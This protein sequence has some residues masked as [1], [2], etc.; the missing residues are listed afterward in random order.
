[1][2]LQRVEE[3]VEGDQLQSL[4]VRPNILEGHFSAATLDAQFCLRTRTIFNHLSVI[5]RNLRG[6]DNLRTVAEP[7]HTRQ[8][9]DG[10]GPVWSGNSK[11]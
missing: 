5:E 10:L 3:L 6:L 7:I 9:R 11:A 8:Q 2:L 4:Q 1:M